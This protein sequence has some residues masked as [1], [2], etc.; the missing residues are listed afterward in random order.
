MSS[1]IQPEHINMNINQ[2]N[3]YKAFI[4]YLINIKTCENEYHIYT[5]EDDKHLKQFG[6]NICGG[7]SI[8][9]QINNKLKELE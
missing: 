6:I 3:L 5:N 4:D 9:T 1:Y 7:K 8:F 2:L